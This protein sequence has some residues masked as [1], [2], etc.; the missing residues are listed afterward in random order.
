MKKLIIKSQKNTPEII[1]DQESDRFEISGRSFPENSKK[2]YLPVFKWLDSFDPGDKEITFR[3]QFYYISSSSIISLLELIK[4]LSNLIKNGSN[5]SIVW[6]YDED[7]EDIR[8]IGDD[9]SKLVSI[10][11]IMEP[12]PR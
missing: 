5:I 2:F 6:A 9:Y 1:F 10:P 8:K 7:D 4:K 11:F 12:I 3:F